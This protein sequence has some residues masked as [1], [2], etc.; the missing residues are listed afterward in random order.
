MLAKTHCDHCGQAIPLPHGITLEGTTVTRNNTS[1]RFTR[2]E[3][4]IFDLLLSR[5]DRC[6]KYTALLEHIYFE[7]HGDEPDTASKA[8][9]VRIFSIRGKLAS[10]GLKIRTEWGVGYVLLDP[11]KKQPKE[12][13][14][15]PLMP[16][17][18]PKGKAPRSTLP[19]PIPPK[20][21]RPL[22]SSPSPPSDE[23]SST[24]NPASA[25]ARQ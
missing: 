23:S 9:S 24:A 16:W 25:T 6:V 4:L 11:L 2:A 20:G 17:Q 7:N 3:A 22:L 10:L 5:I 12:I 8:L 1:V 19:N 21:R 14:S 18:N 15:C 13:S